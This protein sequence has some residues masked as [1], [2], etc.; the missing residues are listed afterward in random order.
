VDPHRVLGVKRGASREEVAA[1][2]RR[3]AKRWHPDH[4]GGRPAEEKM[5]RI[6]AAYDLLREGMAEELARVRRAAPPPPPPR[7]AGGWLP[8][9]V[10]RALGRELTRMLHPGERV[11]F[12]TPAALWAS[13]RAVL[14]VTDRRLLWLLDDAVNH[15]VRWVALPA[16]AEAS[17]RPSWP[18]RRRAVL[19]VATADGRR[20]AFADLRPPTAA[21][22]ARHLARAAA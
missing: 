11:A 17:A 22:I 10:R 3:L 15:R 4:G 1:T 16:I 2:Y 5:A 13:P 18:L 19:R 6:N 14:A 9:H 8:A 12:V 20:F 21:A 7:A